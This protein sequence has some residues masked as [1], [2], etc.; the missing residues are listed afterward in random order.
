MFAFEG[1]VSTQR[2]KR[3]RPLTESDSFAGCRPARRLV[4]FCV[5][6][7]PRLI[8]R[9]GGLRPQKYNTT[10]AR[11]APKKRSGVVLFRAAVYHCGALQTRRRRGKAARPKLRLGR[12]RDGRL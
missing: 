3:S 7:R 1:G 2:R 11:V 4:L 12:E 5:L 8:R 9:G 6:S 10:G